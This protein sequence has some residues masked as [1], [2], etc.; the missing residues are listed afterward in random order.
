MGAHFAFK[1]LFACFNHTGYDV[2]IGFL[3]IDYSARAHETHHRMTHTN[4]A[5]Y[6]MFWDRLMGTFRPY[7]SGLPKEAHE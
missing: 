3:G 7:D 6:V 2:A 1:S 5:Q 4:F